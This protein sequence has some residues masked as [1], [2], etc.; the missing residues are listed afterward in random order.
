MK[1][2]KIALCALFGLAVANP[3]PVKR[4]LTAIDTALEVVESAIAL[5][6]SDVESF[7]SSNPLSG[8]ILC[9]TIVALQADVVAVTVVVQA[10]GLLVQSDAQAVETALQPIVDQ[11]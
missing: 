1:F 6:E 3:T 8:I 10:T 5:V 9:G 2:I 7:A 11:I 4:D